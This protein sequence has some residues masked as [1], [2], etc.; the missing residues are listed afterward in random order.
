MQ[1]I[2][3]H[4]LLTDTCELNTCKGIWRLSSPAPLLLGTYKYSQ[5]VIRA[6]PKSTKENRMESRGDQRGSSPGE[7][8]AHS[9]FPV[10]WRFVFSHNALSQLQHTLLRKEMFFCKRH[11]PQLSL[12]A[13]A[14]WVGVFMF[15][16]SR[17]KLCLKSQPQIAQSSKRQAN[18][19]HAN[20]LFL[21]CYYLGCYHIP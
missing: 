5:A 12:I 16:L 15:I 11:F 8:S 19:I 2:A 4:R 3:V 17:L 18:E 14:L 13:Y 9:E 21:F 1:I 7:G 6:A 10:I 20:R